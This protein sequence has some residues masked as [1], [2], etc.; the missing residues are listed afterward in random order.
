MMLI[1]FSWLAMLWLWPGGL[2]AGVPAVPPPAAPAEVVHFPYFSRPGVL[3]F[4]R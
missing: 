1:F 2:G 4:L 3:V